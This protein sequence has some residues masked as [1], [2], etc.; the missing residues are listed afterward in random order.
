MTDVPRKSPVLRTFAA[1]MFVGFVALAV[2]YFPYNGLPP[3]LWQLSPLFGAA[4]GATYSGV[5]ALT[6]RWLPL[7]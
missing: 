4:V 3:Q 1:F 6:G 2:L 7:P 5:L